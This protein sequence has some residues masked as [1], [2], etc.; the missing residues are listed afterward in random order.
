MIDFALTPMGVPAATADAIVDENAESRIQGLQASLALLALIAL[1][2]VIGVG[3]IPVRPVGSREEE[4]EE[5]S[6]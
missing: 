3:G 2:A 5:L 6:G 4:A 1:I